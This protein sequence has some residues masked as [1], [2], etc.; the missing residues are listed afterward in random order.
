MKN[1]KLLFLIGFLFSFSFAVMAQTPKW[2]KMMKDPTVNFYDVQNEFNDYFKDRDNGK[3]SGWKQFKRWEYF[4]E[5]RVYPSGDRTVITPGIAWVEAQKFKDKYSCTNNHVRNSWTELGPHTSAVVTGHWS[6]GVGRIDAIAVD[7]SNSDIVYCGSPSGGL[8]KTTDA[9]STWTPLTDFLPV[10][11]ISSIAI[12]PNNSDIIYI[13]TGDKDSYNVYSIGVLKSIDGGNTWNPTGLNWL[14][15]QNSIIHKI[16]INPNNSQSLFAATSD[17]LYKTTNAAQSWT[18]VLNN[19]LE[20]IE[21]KPGDTSIVYG[22]SNSTFYKSTNGGNSFNTVNVNIS[23]RAQ[24]TVTPADNSYVY[25]VSVGTGIFQSTNSG[26]SFTFKGNYPDQGNV[27]WY[28]CQRQLRILM[29]TSYMLANLKHGYQI[30]VGRILV[31]HRS[32]YGIIVLATC[33]AIFTK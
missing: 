11:G 19:E 14:I 15:T 16:I 22:V 5:Q 12:D 3:G 32:G 1:Y 7:P 33:I 28:A 10:I 26:T 31:K 9:G 2:V 29:Q 17:G 6:P 8:W 20:D 13:S 27:S 30:M 18:N 21:F 24:I 4:T 25:L 23:D